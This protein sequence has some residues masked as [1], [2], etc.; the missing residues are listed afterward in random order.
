[1]RCQCRYCHKEYDSLKSRSDYTGFCSAYCQHAKA[2]ELGY[3]RSRGV[4]ECQVL[5]RAECIGDVPVESERVKLRA[6]LAELEA[7]RYGNPSRIA[8]IKRLLS[9]NLR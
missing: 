5:S 6:E 4:S 3:R 8:A 2:H 9:T 1:M 7:S